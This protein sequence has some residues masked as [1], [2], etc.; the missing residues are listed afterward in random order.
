MINLIPEKK[1]VNKPDSMD[2]PN[3][4][5]KKVAKPLAAG[6]ELEMTD[7]QET[8]SEKEKTDEGMHDKHKEMSKMEMIKPMKDM[9]TEMKEM[10]KEMGP[11]IP[12]ILK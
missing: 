7:D 10:D 3:D 12:G 6:D 2:T 8:I 11:A 9:E 4:G 5:E 1:K